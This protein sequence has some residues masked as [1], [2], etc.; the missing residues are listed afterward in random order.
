M[1]AADGVVYAVPENAP[2]VIMFD[3]KTEE[4]TLMPP[5]LGT[6]NAKYTQ[7]V[8]GPDG[9]YMLGLTDN[10]TKM[11]RI[12][13]HSQTVELFGE[14]VK[15]KYPAGVLAPDG[16]IY[17]IPYS[18]N[19][20][21]LR[22]NVVSKTITPFGPWL[23]NGANDWYRGALA[24]DGRIYCVPRCGTH[25]LCIDPVAGSV[26]TLKQ[27]LPPDLHGEK[28]C[29]S[30]CGPDGSVFGLPMGLPSRA[31]KIDP[32]SG[33][34]PL[35]ALLTL[36]RSPP[37][38]S[39]F[40]RED[41]VRDVF[42]NLLY[43]ALCHVPVP[44]LAS[45]NENLLHKSGAMTFAGAAQYLRQ[46]LPELFSALRIIRVLSLPL[47]QDVGPAFLTNVA[48]A[49]SILH[50]KWQPLPA[51]AAKWS[52]PPP[53]LKSLR[54]ACKL[55]LE[56][57]GRKV[58]EIVWE[59]LAPMITN[60][61]IEMVGSVR[62]D[63]THAKPMLLAVFDQERK[64]SLRMYKKQLRRA[65]RDPTYPEYKKQAKDLL[66]KC[67]QFGR[68]KAH[69]QQTISSFPQLYIVAAHLHERFN[70]LLAELARRCSG[71][72]AILAPLKGCGRALEKLVLRPGVPASPVSS[73]CHTGMSSEG[74]L[75]K[76]DAK[77]LVDVLRGGLE[78]PDFTVVVYALDLLTLL[79][80]EMGNKEK[81]QAAGFDLDRFQI[82]IIHLKDRFTTPTSGGWADGLLSFTFAHGDSTQHVMELQLQHSQMLSVRKAGKAHNQYNSFRSAFELLETVGHEPKDEFIHESGR[83]FSTEE[84]P[85]QSMVVQIATLEDRLSLQ[86]KQMEAQKKQM[87]AQNKQIDFL[88]L[89]NKQMEEMRLQIADLMKLKKVRT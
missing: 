33:R 47:A 30:A 88:L 38:L 40:L 8:L 81:A 75:S 82:R 89:Q 11:L 36:L 83:L 68:S 84:E 7:T 14:D 69:R 42:Q 79:D 57:G 54:A 56:A 18:P 65:R 70:A 4:F 74:W 16:Y 15:G 37:V 49:S 1:A 24:A 3:P 59:V 51:S 64:R 45:E 44:Q 29:G 67:A 6:G 61:L 25:V 46:H 27:P 73:K 26:F 71:A 17:A 43:D 10:A 80:V 2:N 48:H 63:L 62:A 23:G 41:S 85:D 28:L 53:P 77:S 22:I 87:E 78:C 86:N 12:D 21:V 34:P 19:G 39:Q 60:I 31:I 32:P 55:M 58:V 35:H 72:K 20:R 5:D 52:W 76:L 9:R 13:T 50:A 66:A